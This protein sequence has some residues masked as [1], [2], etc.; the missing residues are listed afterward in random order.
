MRTLIEQSSPSAKG[1]SA[2]STILK[3]AKTLPDAAVFVRVNHNLAQ[4]EN[5]TTTGL[6]KMMRGLSS[7]HQSFAA[8]QKRR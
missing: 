3:A 8:A 1:R 5:A 2:Q 7:S 6:P 4:P